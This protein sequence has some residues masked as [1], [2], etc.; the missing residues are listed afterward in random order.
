[1]LGHQGLPAHAEC[2]GFSCVLSSHVGWSEGGPRPRGLPAWA[3]CPGFSHGVVR[4]LT[5]RL[6]SADMVL[7]VSAA[8]TTRL[9]PC[10]SREQEEVGAG[11]VWGR[12]GTGELGAEWPLRVFWPHQAAQTPRW[13]RRLF[14]R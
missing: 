12:G 1:M 2:P 6:L 11:A 14:P 8:K 5:W 3:E 4:G 13:G 10:G 7:P 9:L